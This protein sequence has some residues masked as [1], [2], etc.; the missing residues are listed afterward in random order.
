MVPGLAQVDLNLKNDV[1]SV[2][3][4]SGVGQCDSLARAGDDLMNIGDDQV[5]DTSSS[6][7]E[8]VVLK[9]L[10]ASQIIGGSMPVEDY[11]LEGVS[12]DDFYAVASPAPNFVDVNTV[13]EFAEQVVFS[14]DAV[15]R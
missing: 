5:D 15:I 4:V 9:I 2:M 11:S 7:D 8:D 13:K 12:R 1:A 3:G 14:E 10:A 6:I